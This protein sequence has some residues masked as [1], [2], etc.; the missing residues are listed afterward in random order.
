MPLRE[1]TSKQEKKTKK[2][3]RDTKTEQSSSTKTSI[4]YRR[5]NKAK[6]SSTP[7]PNLKVNNS[8]TLRKMASE[9]L[10]ALFEQSSMGALV[11]EVQPLG[12]GS[13][14]AMPAAIPS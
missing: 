7:F 9:Y 8:L 1:P 4:K 13:E 6:L 2:A 11:E 12:P 10:V 14:V 3:E 5:Y